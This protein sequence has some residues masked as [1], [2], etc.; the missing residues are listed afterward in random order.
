MSI[1]YTKSYHFLTRATQSATLL[2]CFCAGCASAT[3]APGTPPW[4]FCAGA[5]ARVLRHCAWSRLCIY[6]HVCARARV[7]CYTWRSLVR[8]A[9][10]PFLYASAPAPD[11]HRIYIYAKQQ[12]M[13]ISY[14]REAGGTIPFSIQKAID[15][16]PTRRNRL[17][18]SP[19][20]A[21]AVLPQP[22]PPPRPFSR[23]GNNYG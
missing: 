1:L 2:A 14:I 23:G 22:L 18:F 13:S 19:A 3:V 15:S 20:F 6:A 16:W 9:C 7:Y 10:H 21:R 8:A 12:K 4:S 17:R 5:G 11:M